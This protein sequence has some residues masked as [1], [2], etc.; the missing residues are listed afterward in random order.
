MVTFLNFTVWS[1]ATWLH[2]ETAVRVCVCGRRVQT[3]CKWERMYVSETD[4]NCVHSCSSYMEKNAYLFFSNRDHFVWMSSQVLSLSVCLSLCVC[5][6]A[7]RETGCRC[8]CGSGR[9]LI[10]QLRQKLFTELLCVGLIESER[11]PLTAPLLRTLQVIT[12]KSLFPCIGSSA[13]L[14]PHMQPTSDS[15]ITCLLLVDLFRC[16]VWQAI[17]T[18]VTLQV[19]QTISEVPGSVRGYSLP[20]SCEDSCG[21]L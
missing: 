21:G 6:S 7:E 18:H 11:Q 3:T 9:K 20:N 13:Q 19:L 5:L 10:G 14:R 1:M 12:H 2:G 17:Q 15:F 4:V 8:S 16:T